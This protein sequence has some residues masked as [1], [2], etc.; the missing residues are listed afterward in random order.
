M[1][2]KILQGEKGEKKIY[3]EGVGLRTH[4]GTVKDRKTER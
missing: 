2:E 4:G 3:G 1:D